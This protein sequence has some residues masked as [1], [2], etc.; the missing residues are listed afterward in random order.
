MWGSCPTG[1]ALGWLA[2]QLLTRLD[3]YLVETTLTTVIAFGSYLLAEQFHVSGVLAVLAAGLVT[4]GLSPRSMSPTTRIVVFNFWG[5]AAFLANS[6]IFF[7]I[8]LHI[9]P[10]LLVQ[11]WLPIL[12]A[13]DAVIL[14]RA[15]ASYLASRYV[16]RFPI[17]WSHVLFLGRPARCHRIGARPQPASDAGAGA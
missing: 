5:F 10:A 6:A 15:L 16:A 1:L 14:S 13:L 12:W 17:K 3:D 4:G 9:D 7:L 8:G 2:D 11:S